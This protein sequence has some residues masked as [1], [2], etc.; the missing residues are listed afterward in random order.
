MSTEIYLPRLGSTTMEFGRLVN[1]L[2][3]EGDVVEEEQPLAEVET[4]KI[5]VEIPSPAAGTVLQL[6]WAPNDEI[7]VGHTMGYIGTPG[8]S[9]P[10]A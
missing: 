4:D 2:V 10:T 1:W 9:V 3:A 7:P 5:V 8:E 6:R